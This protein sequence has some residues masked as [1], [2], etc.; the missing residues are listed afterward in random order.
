MNPVSNVTAKAGY[1]PDGR[2]LSKAAVDAAKNRV[3]EKAKAAKD[4]K[5]A[6]KAKKK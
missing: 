6:S 2:K 5:K 3:E 1:T 4:A